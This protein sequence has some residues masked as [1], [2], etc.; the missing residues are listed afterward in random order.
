MDYEKA[1]IEELEAEIQRLGALRLEIRNQQL[2]ATAA[3]DAKLHLRDAEIKVATLSDDQIAALT[4]V[5]EA[6]HASVMVAA[7]EAG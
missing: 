4:Q 1:T 6:R 3:L 7:K 5:I 2:E